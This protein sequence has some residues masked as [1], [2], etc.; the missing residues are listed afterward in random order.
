MEIRE[1]SGLKFGFPDGS[2]AIKFDDSAVNF[3]AEKGYDPA[4]GARP[5]KRAVQT[6]VENPLSKELLEGKFGEGSVINVS[7]DGKEL[8]FK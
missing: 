4:F 2:I 1:E 3:I 6:W 8:I 7:S 5:I